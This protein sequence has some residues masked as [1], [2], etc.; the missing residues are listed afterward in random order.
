MTVKLLTQ[1]HLLFLTLE[2]GYTGSSESTLVKMPH[3][4][5]SRVVAHMLNLVGKKIF[6][7]FCSKHMELIK[8][9]LGHALI[10]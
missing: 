4:W 1:Q 7:S 8:T 5:K 10:G 9:H 6:T 3:C 2:G